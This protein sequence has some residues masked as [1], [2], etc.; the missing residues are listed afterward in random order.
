MTDS[1]LIEQQRT[2][3]QELA[4]LAEETAAAERQIEAEFTS[5]QQTVER[6][7][8]QVRQET[9]T[10][11]TTERETA[12]KRLA[13]AQTRMRA[14]FDAAHVATQNE[15]KARLGAVTQ[16][17]NAGKEKNKA[18]FE[19]ASWTIGAVCEAAVNRTAT[20]L[21]ETQ[22]HVGK[23]REILRDLQDRADKAAAEWR[24]RGDDEADG[25]PPP[26]AAPV[27][28]AEGIAAAAAELDRLADA[29]LPTFAR[30][31]RVVWLAAV[32]CL[33][34]TAPLPF[35]TDAHY[36][37]AVGLV[38]AVLLVVLGSARLV[39]LTRPKV[40][41]A[42]ATVRRLAAD[43]EAW[44]VQH[45]EEVRAQ[46][47]AEREAARAKQARD[48]EDAQA[49][50]QTQRT[51]LK[52]IRDTDWQRTEQEL[53]ERWAVVRK[54]HDAEARRLEEVGR[55][56]LAEI[57]EHY[58]AEGQQIDDNYYRSLEDNRRRREAG[59]TALIGRWR[60]GLD[61]T[62]T[63]ARAIDDTCNRF[64]PA[65]D[66]PAWDAWTPPQDIPPVLRFGTYEVSLE[67]VSAAL[68]EDERLRATW[69]APFTLPAGLPFPQRGSLLLRA[70]DEGR[71]AAV[72]AL[73]ALMLR[74]LTTIPPGKVRFTIVDPVGLGQNFAAFMHLA[75]HDEALVGS[76][77]WTETTHI[78]QRLADLTGHMENV[79]QKYLRNQFQ[80]IQEYN[81]HAGEVAEPFR[82]LVVANF[83]VNFSLEAARRLVSIAT[84]GPRCGVY[85]L[86][87]L[88]EAQPVP[89]GF[90]SEDLEAG[91]A[92][93][94]WAKDRFGWREPDF[95]KYPL[96][97][98]GSPPAD[99]CNR[100]MQ[101][102]G[103][104]ARA[105]NR[106]EVP[107]EF[108]APP[109]EQWW[110]R[111]S[112]SGLAVPLGRA[113]ATKRQ[114][115]RL[116]QGT[117]HHVLIAGKTGSGKSTLLHALITNLALCYSPDE[118]E[119]YLVDFKK[120]V[121]F[122][123]YAAEHLP[124][125]RVVAIESEREFGLSVLQR[126]DAEL[127]RR[128]ELFRQAGAQNLAGYR[129]QPDQPVLPRVLLIVDEFQEF[130]VEDDRLAQEAARLLDR[131]VRQ[132]RAFGMHVLLGS[133]TLGGANT[134]ARSTLDQM[135]VRIALQCSEADAH[136]IL[137]EDNGAAR[138][139]SRPGE[140]IYNDANGLVEG[141]NPFQV[142]WLADAAREEYLT[143]LRYLDAVHPPRPQIVFEGDAPAD[144]SGNQQLA[145]LLRTSPP[146]GT[147]SATAWLGDAVAIK[148]PTA[149][150]FRAQ[151]DNHLLILG[152]Q[153]E[154][155]LG[156]LAVALVS[157]AAHHRSPQGA[158]FYILDGTPDDSP[159][160][161]Y[162]PRLAALLPDTVR[163]GGV[164]ELPALLAEVAA[165]VE[166]RQ[167]TSEAAPCYLIVYGLHRFR[168]LRK[169]DDDFGFGRREEKATPAQQ[170]A[171]ILREGPLLGVHAL[172]WCDT[173]ANVNRALDRQALRGFEMK[174][175]FQMS[176][177]DSSLLIDTPLAS[178]LGPYRAY[179]HSEDQGR[180]EKFR[181]YRPPSPAWLAEAGNLLTGAQ[182]AENQPEAC[183]APK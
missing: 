164:R 41:A 64:F 144:A 120:G 147:K 178:K 173:L 170:F 9:T 17:Y 97:L 157:L 160:R 18:E 75:D 175:L 50:Y 174:V 3:L 40:F 128:G 76:R 136:I 99:L 70:R 103:E 80:N 158:R 111:D 37:P 148:P 124:H 92:I 133:Q 167:G 46:G 65:W 114:E 117:A 140:A 86:I 81:A 105:A 90:R 121:E 12:E 52:Q 47:A 42:R 159:H 77:I 93:L 123:T 33:V 45:L 138:L 35:V 110:Q 7:F 106:V 181:P 56:G 51:I 156:M 27:D 161:D 98:D 19:E 85:T 152:Q 36:W 102:V 26:S 69:L 25:P 87:A 55:A 39:A 150:V 23:Q 15:I 109:A 143:R 145:E 131:L 63:M 1:S 44:C 20:Q 153:D 183:A 30:R 162:W 43:A 2:I 38:A 61:R 113:G 82:V 165:E 59:W 49:R 79:I 48:L 83:P 168:D 104:A 62:A 116:G 129:N 155:A 72:A 21:R 139:L 24:P 142:V 154:A 89:Q 172:V 149:A 179:F 34:A 171:T 108:I 68:P 166:R 78:E 112:R 115:L 60:A 130:F 118:V 84:S 91:S 125:A 163:L 94:T 169:A 8:Q 74:L 180:L 71:S 119:L 135:T 127:T 176:A 22:E 95:A 16:A 54:R 32:A 137:S 4:T 5:R 96:A 29:V 10:R 11:H 58:R 73:Q 67:R 182:E 132:G 151:T 6:E 177:T 101:Q 134:L 13:D 88:D 122:K 107:F 28:P 14:E 57:E 31:R 126:L 146:A 141:N 100:L 66:D 53:R